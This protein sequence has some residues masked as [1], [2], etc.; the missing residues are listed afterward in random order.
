MQLSHAAMHFC[1]H[2]CVQPSGVWSASTTVA[3]W[4]PYLL[5]PRQSRRH[6]SFHRFRIC[7][8]SG[9]HRPC[10]QSGAAGG[11]LLARSIVG[12]IP[13]RHPP[14]FSCRQV[15]AVLKARPVCP[16]CHQRQHDFGMLPAVAANESVSRVTVSRVRFRVTVIRSH[17]QFKTPAREWPGFFISASFKK[18]SPAFRQS[19]RRG[20]LGG[21]RS[22]PDQADQTRFRQS[23]LNWAGNVITVK[24]LRGRKYCV[25]PT[26]S[27]QNGQ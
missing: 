11:Q 13:W 1:S 19:P 16:L 17:R 12:S 24:T 9:R 23:L 26:K 15:S 5:P 14:L 4:T 10:R 22:D 2:C 3:A 8:R 7:E 25:H 27:V 6:R 21:L 18:K 20:V